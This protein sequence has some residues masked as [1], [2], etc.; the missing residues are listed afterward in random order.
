MLT[1]KE[2]SIYNAYLISSRRVKNKPFQLR[3]NFE[4]LDPSIYNSLKKLST[5]FDRNPSI[6]IMD[7]FTAPYVVYDQDNYFEIHFFN[8]RK[9]LK[10]YSLYI[11]QKEMQN[12]DNE[13]TI[14]QCKECCKNIYTYCKENNLTLHD[15]SRLIVGST[16][17]ALQHL[18][19]HKINFYTLH[20]L[21]NERAIKQ[22]EPELLD[23][24]VPD[25]TILLNDTR[26]NFSRSTK[27]KNILR[28]ALTTI[29]HQ[30]TKT[31]LTTN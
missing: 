19:E 11:K 5:F 10:C 8:T 13:D 18:K 30:L 7:F 14:N 22:L 17:I 9:S 28:E 4:N 27:L 15:Y 23:F 1:E 26:V 2:K 12:P 3:K 29:E 31:K 24:L 20:A 16:P 21:N 6:N 25:F